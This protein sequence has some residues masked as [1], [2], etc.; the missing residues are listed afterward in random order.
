[1]LL[2]AAQGT[3]RGIGNGISVRP[4]CVVI[5]ILRFVTLTSTGLTGS[6][7][8]DLPPGLH[9]LIIRIRDTQHRLGEQILSLRVDR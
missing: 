9:T 7:P 3:F 8:P 6:T 4:M 2:G 1:M 5:K